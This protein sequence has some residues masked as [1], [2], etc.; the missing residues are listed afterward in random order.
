MYYLVSSEQEGCV[1]IDGGDEIFVCLNA[2]KSGELSARTI[3]V[4]TVRARLSGFS[5]WVLVRTRAFRVRAFRAFRA[6]FY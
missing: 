5:V 3:I 4:G 2:A 1:E 6:D